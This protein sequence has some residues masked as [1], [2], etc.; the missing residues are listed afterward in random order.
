MDSLYLLLPIALIF[1]G[2]AVALFF[3]A[4][5]DKQFDDLEKEGQRILFD[6]D[7]PKQTKPENTDE[8]QS[9]P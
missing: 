8:S 2:T 6:S 9:K 1:F 3:W 7:Q 4:V 5:K